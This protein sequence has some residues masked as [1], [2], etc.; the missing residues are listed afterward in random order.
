MK[1]FILSVLLVLISLSGFS[2]KINH[3]YTIDSVTMAD[4][5][6]KNIV[7]KPFKGSATFYFG[8]DSSSLLGIS[9]D[10]ETKLYRV[11][12]FLFKH[13]IIDSSNGKKKVLAIIK[14]YGVIDEY[15]LDYTLL[16]SFD[17]RGN[18]LLIS[19]ERAGYVAMF[20][21]KQ[22]KKKRK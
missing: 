21:I 4:M 16:I 7:T 1:H 9:S 18:L 13:Y 5:E 12:A 3:K 20:D 6:S 22:S 19:L 14:A 2:Q 17:S 11:E 10:K 8:K 15:S